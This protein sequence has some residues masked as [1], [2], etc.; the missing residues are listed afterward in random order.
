VQKIFR[1]TEMKSIA[2]H[3]SA[4]DDEVALRASHSAAPKHISCWPQSRGRRQIRNYC[5][6][7]V[8]KLGNSPVG[9]L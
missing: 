6:F 3:I 2:T 8:R 9:L 4:L 1:D 5:A 7:L